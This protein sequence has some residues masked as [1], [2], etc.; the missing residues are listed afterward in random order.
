MKKNREIKENLF[1][2]R[3]VMLTLSG[4][5]FMFGCLRVTPVITDYGE[6]KIVEIRPSD[7]PES[8]N[9]QI[10]FISS[11]DK[12]RTKYLLLNKHHYGHLKIGD[13]IDQDMLDN[14][15]GCDP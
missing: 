11:K 14:N 2:A 12:T 7:Y 1:A 13:S 5:I 6:T 4:F 3:V 10:E 8:N 15:Q 9:I